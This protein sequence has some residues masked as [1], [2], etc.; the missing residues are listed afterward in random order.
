MW[1]SLRSRPG[2]AAER[3]S[4]CEWDAGRMDVMS[5]LLD[6]DPA[7]R[8]QV[9]RDLAGAPEDLIAAERARVADE[10]WGARLLALQRPIGQWP[11]GTPAFSSDAAQRWCFR[12]DRY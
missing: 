12:N 9:M 5:W 8:W 6:S 10:G 11:S 2:R 3:L 4:S 1:R 7:I